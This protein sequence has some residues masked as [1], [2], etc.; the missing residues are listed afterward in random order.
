MKRARQS[1]GM[2]DDAVLV[3]F[4]CLGDADLS[5]A[6]SFGDLTKLLNNYSGAGAWTISPSRVRR[7]CTG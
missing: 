6:T 2:D 5:G 3:K 7:P 1:G 4:S